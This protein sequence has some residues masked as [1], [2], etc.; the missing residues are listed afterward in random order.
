MLGIDTAT[1]SIS[2]NAPITK[3]K[4]LERLAIRD[5]PSF[6]PRRVRI[7]PRPTSHAS[8]RNG[9]AVCGLPAPGAGAV[10]APRH[11]LLVDLG[12]DLAVAGQERLGRAHFGAERQLALGKPVG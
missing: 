7:A 12:D 8:G 3:R 11:P 9:L 10:A 6:C 1:A 4:C 5:S 2:A